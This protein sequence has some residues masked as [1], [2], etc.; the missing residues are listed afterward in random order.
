MERIQLR[1]KHMTSAVPVNNEKDPVIARKTNNRKA[2]N[3]SHVPSRKRLTRVLVP[4]IL[5]PLTGTS[6]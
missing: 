2:R 3:V 4:I 1:I 6:R 5:Y